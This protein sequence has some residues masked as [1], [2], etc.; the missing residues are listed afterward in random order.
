MWQVVCHVV[1]LRLAD[2]LNLDD[3]SFL[4]KCGRSVSLGV[5]NFEG[6]GFG[7]GI[8]VKLGLACATHRSWGHCGR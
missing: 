7:V 3:Y 4:V 1:G 5:L 6:L 2:L 8:G